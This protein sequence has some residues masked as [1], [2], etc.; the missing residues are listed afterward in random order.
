VL[1]TGGGGIAPSAERFDR[2]VS[3]VYEKG[4]ECRLIDPD[5]VPDDALVFMSA[6]VGGG[7]TTEVR[8]RYLLFPSYEDLFVKG[9]DA[10]TRSS[11]SLFPV[12][13]AAVRPIEP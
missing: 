13:G 5:E 11:V 3:G 8:R 10:G 1:A 4:L 2:T 12:P 9:F 6:G 7:V